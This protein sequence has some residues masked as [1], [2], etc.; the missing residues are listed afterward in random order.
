MTFAYMI[1]YKP[2][3]KINFFIPGPLRETS[4]IAMDIG[5]GMQCAWVIEDVFIRLKIYYWL[6]RHQNK[7]A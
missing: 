1:L 5:Y 4:F 3:R 6:A 2:I 7:F